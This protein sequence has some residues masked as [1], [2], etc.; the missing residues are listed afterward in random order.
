LA[1]HISINV[2]SQND[3]TNRTNSVNGSL[4]ITLQLM[5]GPATVNPA[6]SFIVDAI[7]SIEVTNSD[8]G[9]SGFQITFAIGRGETPYSTGGGGFG[10]GIDI[11]SNI[12]SINSLGASETSA[13]DYSLFNTPLLKP[14]T[15]IIIIVNIGIIQRILFDG[16]IT[17]YQISQSESPGTSTL[18]VTGEDYSVLMDMVELSLSY[19]T[20]SEPLIVRTII[21][22]YGLI[23][24]V[25][26]P[27]KLK[28]PNPVRQIPH[29][30]GTDLSH[31]QSLASK[32][33]FIFYV[34]PTDSLGVNLA[35]WGPS[36]RVGIP[37]KAITVNMGAHSNASSISIQNNFRQPK[38]IIGIVED[39]SIPDVI[40]P[41]VVPA[42][43][44]PYLAQKPAHIFNQP[45]VKL[46]LFKGYEDKTAIGAYIEAIAEVDATKDVVTVSGELDTLRY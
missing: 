46:S 30:L 33:N 32:Y 27:I 5:I 29:Q 17:H 14:F 45:F 4:G 8:S 15:R 41:V 16:F 6:P 18:T 3:L 20:F 19:P 24:I 11:G 23:P 10:S 13:M 44:P 26:P 31:I 9:R 37:Q 42:P 1:I 7:K 38:S 21:A 43:I 25:I 40:I 35:Y 28:I 36:I 12:S 39:E 22:R 2:I 34:E